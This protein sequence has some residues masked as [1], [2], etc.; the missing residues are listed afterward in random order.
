V[1]KLL[2]GTLL[3]LFRAQC[4]HDSPV[5]ETEKIVDVA[6]ILEE[7]VVDK[8]ATKLYYYATMGILPKN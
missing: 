3:L 4:F 1:L 5:A 2:S 7:E 6:H 8:D